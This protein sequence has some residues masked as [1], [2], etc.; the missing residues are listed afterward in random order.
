MRNNNIL[1]VTF[2]QLIAIVFV[3]IV[4]VSCQDD[5]VTTTTTTPIEVK[6]GDKPTITF[7][8]QG[9]WHLSSNQL[10]CTFITPAGELLEMSGSTGQHTI[11]LKISDLNNGMESSEA[12][13]AIRIDGQTKTL[14]TIKRQPNTP[15]IKLYNENG[16]A[17]TSL[18]LGYKEWV[19]TRIESNFRYAAIDIPEWVE[20]GTKH[21][22]GTIEVTTSITGAPGET[23]E[24][25]LRIVNDG[26]RETYTISEEDGKSIT[27]A[28]NNGTTIQLPITYAGMGTNYLTFAG[29]TAY[30]YGWEVS[31]DGTTFRQADPESGAITT[32]EDSL[33]YTITAQ[34]NNYAIVFFENR[35]ERGIPNYV[36]YG[37]GDNDCWMHFDKQAQSLS[38]DSHNGAP[39]YGIV[40]AL[41]VGIDQGIN[42]DYKSNIVE[43]DYTSGIGLEAITA[44]YAEYIIADLMQHDLEPKGDYYG[45][46]AYH[47]LTALDIYC[48]PHTDSELSAKYGVE[49]IYI[50]DFVNPVDNKRPGVIVD[51]RIE[52]WTTQT[53]EQGIASAEVWLGDKQLKMS[54]G[55]YYLGENTDERMA[56]HLWGPND[57][58]NGQNMVVIFK[59]NNE[60]KK[61][62]VV[63]PPSVL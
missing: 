6:A 3:A 26:K 54:E 13:I 2:I 5:I 20:V 28:N 23:T 38:I 47:S 27:F 60:A 51:P 7:T 58:W 43:I 62:L 56:I 52:N 14:A 10:W 45:M 17:T 9:D 32:I 50:T 42:S 57:G 29:P 22:N 8:A 12:K 34:D 40:L 16:E 25:L 33:Q 59:V 39:R 18:K 37:E 41:P 55:E 49:E 44:T 30:T 4:G 24:V 48:A 35:I 1:R 19:T 21:E 61:I 53:F 11:T 36:C 46:Y 63:T 15:Y 31:L